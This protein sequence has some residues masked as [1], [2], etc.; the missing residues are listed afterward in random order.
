MK[1]PRFDQTAGRSWSWMAGSGA[2]FSCA[3][4]WWSLAMKLGDIERDR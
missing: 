4:A 3:C 2:T 1:P